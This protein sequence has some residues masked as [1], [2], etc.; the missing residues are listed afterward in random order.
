MAS[1]ETTLKNAIKTELDALVTAGIL[2]EVQVDDFKVSNIFDRDIAKYPAAIL[3]SPSIEAETLTNRD[4]IRIYSFEIVILEKGENI[5]NATQIEDL[6]DEIMKRF[7]D[8]PTLNGTADGG[9]EPSASPVATISDRSRSFIVFSIIIKA[10][11][12]YTRT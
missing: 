11:A 12:T 5:Q 1:I 9:V 4:N 6:R 10:R 2:G 3:L 8:N 7:D